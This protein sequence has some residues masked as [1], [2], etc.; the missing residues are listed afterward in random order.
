MAQ[1]YQGTTLLPLLMARVLEAK[2]S[3][4]DPT[5]P[6]HHVPDTRHRHHHHNP[7]PHAHI[8]KPT[9]EDG[10]TT[11][12]SS[13]LSSITTISIN[14]VSDSTTTD[15]NTGDYYDYY[16]DD[17]L[18][19]EA[20]AAIHWI[21]IILSAAVLVVG[22]MGNALVW[23]AVWRNPRMRSA[24]NIF[25]VNLAVA[26]FL[27]ILICLPPTMTEDITGIWYL[28]PEMCK[29][30]KC[31]QKVSVFVSVLTLTAIALERW[32]A[33]CEPLMFRQT[34]VRAKRA[35]AVVWLLSL[36]SAVPDAISLDII[37]VS[38]T[39]R[40]CGPTWSEEAETFHLWAIFV[41][42][43]LV[44]LCIMTFT[45]V[46]VAL[47]LWRSNFTDDDDGRTSVPRAQMI[48]RRK[49]A[50]MLIMVVAMFAVCYLP[51]YVLF[52]FRY[53]GIL[54]YFP[55]ESIKPLF[56]SSHWLCYFN[57]ALNPTIYN[58]MSCNFRREFRI[59]CH[60]CCRRS[61]THSSIYEAMRLRE[62]SKRHLR[63]DNRTSGHATND[64][65]CTL[66]TQTLLLGPS[67]SSYSLLSGQR[68]DSDPNLSMAPPA[69][70]GCNNSGGGA[71]CS[72]NC[73]GG[74]SGCSNAN[75][76]L[77]PN[78]GQG[79]DATSPV[80]E[81]QRSPGGSRKM[82]VVVL[83]RNHKAISS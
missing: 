37:P 4:G 19:P 1:G 49:K 59:A 22:L 21:F 3:G 77:Y 11:H 12:N 46:K 17:G 55:P 34:S 79:N 29:L 36:S 35:I 69:C 32:M 66:Q 26:D 68:H 5:E 2:A 23:F 28:G 50:K 63:N 18:T 42:F 52:I 60:I 58:F 78:G 74:Y 45:Y 62:M 51:V 27:V 20:T 25:L 40:M 15:N 9:Q 30:V 41:I 76:G 47:C 71:S 43:Y 8:V 54:D 72:R 7:R 31:L 83:Q 53:T 75:G 38:E 24:T 67:A 80:Q 44:P 73:G 64:N 48:L 82:R 61:S 70:T 33:I 14:N 6:S 10:M 16:Q 56:L 81:R 13:F 57:S 39:A 65:S